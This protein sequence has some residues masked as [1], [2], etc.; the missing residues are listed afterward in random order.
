MPVLTSIYCLGAFASA[1]RQGALPLNM[2]KK[3][4]VIVLKKT[5][6]GRYTN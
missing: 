2:Q 3:N 4:V 6:P 1:E 5:L